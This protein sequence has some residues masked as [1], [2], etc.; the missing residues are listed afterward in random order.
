MK[1]RQF[2]VAGASIG[3][4]SAYIASS[5]DALGQAKYPQRPITIIVH[6]APGGTTDLLG[7]LLAGE[8][9]PL[10]GQNVIVENRPGANGNIGVSAA[11]RSA[12]DG[13][14]LLVASSSALS[15]PA[16]GPVPYDFQTDFAPVAYL[17][18]API[19][20]LTGPKSGLNTF[21]DFVARAKAEP[22]KLSYGSPGHGGIGH[23]AGELLNLRLG[24]NTVHVPYNGQGPVMNAV[25]GGHIDLGITT[26][27]GVAPH[28]ASG[29]MK[30]LV[31]TGSEPWP[32]LAQV[33]TV[34]ALGIQN[35]EVDVSQMLLA[36][37]G[38]PQAILDRLEK[39]VLGVLA[40]PEIKERML[41][42]G[43]AVRPLG[44][45][46]LRKRMDAELALWK[47]LVMKAG[48]KNK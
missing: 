31:Q 21:Q 34:G 10:L 1:R 39:E 26:I 3:A 33:P 41:K 35:A 4:W 22:G 19:V 45:Q 32:D 42:V 27:A 38:T 2:L 48:I 12:P 37:S 6:F 8:L 43:F 13:Y 29:A 24:I 46:E 15:N 28:I 25:M 20:V 17:G 36:P 7:R 44:A 30:A 23:L 16:M 9:R 40:R 18:S 14:T 47:D 5:A 11:A